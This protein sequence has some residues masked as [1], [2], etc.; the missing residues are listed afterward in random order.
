M[1]ARTPAAPRFGVEEEFLLL[2]RVTG[3][4]RDGAEALIRALPD[5]RC[6]HEFFHSQVET[7]TSV[8]ESGE[9]ALH[10]LTTFRRVAAAAAAAEGLVL[11]GTGLPPVGGSQPG[12]VVEKPRYLDID[13]T[14]RGMVSRYYSTGTHVHVEVPSRDAGV[15]VF[16]RIAVWSPALIALTANSPIWLGGDS[17]YA[18]WRYLSIQQWP[19]SGYPPY[20]ANANDYDR[21]VTDL[22]RAGALL[23]PALV[24]WSIRLSEKYP[25]IELRTADSQLTAGDA[26]AFALIVRALVARA[27]RERT[28]GEPFERAQPDVLRGAHWIAAR[29]GLAGDLVHPFLGEPRPAAEVVSALMDYVSGELDDAGDLATIERFLERRYTQQ[30]PAEQQRAA[31]NA[32]GIAEL[33]RLYRTS[34]DATD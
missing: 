33:L 22:V 15:E 3:Q 7:A 16:A 4:P 18:S 25:T 6:E 19:S 5:L 17:G 14:M 10:E 11:A 1:T 34:H 27:L 26:V 32:G 31:W 29:N 28:A 8:C 13:R 30:G 2:D 12:R 23:D 9:A 24:N 20:F 21:V